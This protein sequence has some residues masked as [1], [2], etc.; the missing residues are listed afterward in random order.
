MQSLGRLSQFFSPKSVDEQDRNNEQ[1]QKEKKTPII[2][3]TISVIGKRA[4]HKKK[5]LLFF[6]EVQYINPLPFDRVLNSR[7]GNE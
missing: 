3:N 5:I 4:M 6:R 2:L 1:E 7:L